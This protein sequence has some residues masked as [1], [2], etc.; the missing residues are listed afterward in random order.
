MLM[1]DPNLQNLNLFEVVYQMICEK[2]ND[3]Y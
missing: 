1:I 3:W 2:L